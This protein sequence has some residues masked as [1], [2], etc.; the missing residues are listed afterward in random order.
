MRCILLKLVDSQLNG[1]NFIIKIGL[2]RRGPLIIMKEKLIH[3][4]NCNQ[5]TRTLVKNRY[6][7]GG[8]RALKLKRKV[9]HCTEC[10]KRR[11]TKK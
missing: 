10:N 3:C 2:R 1:L 5:I 4:S 9:E 7:S 11:I 8:K 6:A